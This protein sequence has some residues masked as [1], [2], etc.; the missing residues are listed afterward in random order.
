MIT[1]SG[2]H[3]LAALAL[4]TLVCSAVPQA[5]RGLCSSSGVFL[6]SP[7]PTVILGRR[8]ELHSLI[9]QLHGFFFNCKDILRSHVNIFEPIKASRFPDL[10]T[11]SLLFATV[12][13]CQS[14]VEMPRCRS[15]ISIILN[16]KDET[17]FP[18]T[19]FR[20]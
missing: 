10:S 19:V 9:P 18:F 11:L 8:F 2:E 3:V 15:V 17:H 7:L 20:V 12:V 1:V 5:T 16:R 4:E 14:S 13:N 6:S